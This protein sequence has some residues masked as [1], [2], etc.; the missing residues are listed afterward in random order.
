MRKGDIMATN[1]EATITLTFT[2]S[3][4]APSKKEAVNQIMDNF[5]NDYGFR[6]SKEEITSFKVGVS[7]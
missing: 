7:E 6:I 4:E 1:Y 2:E 3:V 5:Y